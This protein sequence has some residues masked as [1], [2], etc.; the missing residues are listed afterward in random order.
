MKPLL[1]DHQHAQTLV[2]SELKF[3]ANTP[4]AHC[5][6]ET[7][8]RQCVPDSVKFCL[9]QLQQ[10]E[11]V[12]ILE[13]GSGPASALS[14]LP[15]EKIQVY[16]IDPLAHEYAALRKSEWPFG[17]IN[18]SAEEIGRIFP[19]GMFDIVFSANAL[20]HCKAPFYAIRQICNVLKN[21]GFFCFSF[22][23]KEA[24]RNK[25]QGL[26]K[27]NF[28]L[29]DNQIIDTDTGWRLN[30]RTNLIL[31]KYWGTEEW[32]VTIFQKHDSES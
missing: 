1:S 7:F 5:Y 4:N 23:P 14:S 25:F 29:K 8:L 17:A 21:E 15:N 13:V 24:D 26:H 19:D 18:I 32:Q 30:E 11:R 20:D 2:D 10:K 31:V 22:K 16:V 3:W 28:E 6:D 27:F 12:H 9:S